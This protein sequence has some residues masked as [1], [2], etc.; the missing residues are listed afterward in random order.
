MDYK[1]FIGLF[2]GVLTTLSLLPQ[3]IK[4]Y[5]TKLTRDIS[6]VWTAMLSVGILFWL[7]YGILLKDIAL[8]F[9]N[10]T[11]FIFSGAVLVGKLKYRKY[12]EV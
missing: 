4:V 3:V 1:T 8:I 5:K 6:L 12:E 10:T 2:A 9:A 11:G 7:V